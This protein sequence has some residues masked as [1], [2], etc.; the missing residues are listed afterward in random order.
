MAEGDIH[1][2]QAF[3][4]EVM[5]GTLDLINDVVKVALVA[6]HTL[7]EDGDNVWADVS[8]EEITDAS[9]A[10]QTLG[11]KAVTDDGTGTGTAV[12][13]KWDANDA[14]FASLTGTD[15]N[16]AIIFDDTPT[17]TV[18]DLLIA[19]VELTTSTNGGDYTLSWNANGIIRIS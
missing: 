10:Q 3:K 16:Y 8:A 1:V 11:G 13:G 5:K 14:T 9:Y 7:D 19:A 12:K 17:G 4:T 18:A 6:A 15:P 2:Y